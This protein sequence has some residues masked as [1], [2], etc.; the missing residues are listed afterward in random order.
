M[1]FD[2][3]NFK[4]LNGGSCVV[5]WIGQSAYMKGFGFASQSAQSASGRI[6]GGS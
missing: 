5:G 3:P 2:S 6:G 1:S 4:A